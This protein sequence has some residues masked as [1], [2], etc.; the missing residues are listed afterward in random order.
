M[1]G[2]RLESCGNGIARLWPVDGVRPVAVIASRHDGW[3]ARPCNVA[4]TR[5]WGWLCPTRA[6]AV[7]AV[8][9]W[10]DAR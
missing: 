1:S 10:L 3:F 2:Y 6:G 7:A 5:G 4:G 8:I 9:A